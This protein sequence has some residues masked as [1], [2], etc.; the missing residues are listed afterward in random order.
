MAHSHITRAFHF[1]LKKLHLLSCSLFNLTDNEI[2]TINA[3]ESYADIIRLMNES[4]TIADSARNEL[5]RLLNLPTGTDNVTV[6]AN[7]L[8][9]SSTR[10]LSRITNL[11]NLLT[12]KF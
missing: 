5:N 7:I 8:Y 4:R 6:Q 12:G 10:L 3:T 1:H 9:G 11:L 2:E